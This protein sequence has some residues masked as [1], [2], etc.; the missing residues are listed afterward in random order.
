MFI[1]SDGV[2]DDKGEDQRCKQILYTSKITD[3]FTINTFGYGN[4]HDLKVLNHISNLKGGQFFYIDNIQTLSEC[5][6][7]AMSGML[8]IKAQNAM[9]NIK[10]INQN[11]KI[12]KIFGDD[13]FE[14]KIEFALEIE[15]PSSKQFDIQQAD[16]LSIELQGL[17]IEINTEFLKQSKLILQFSNQQVLAEQNELVEINY[18]RAKAG[19]IIGQAKQ[20]ANQKNFDQAQQLLNKMID[21]IEESFF[22]NNNQLLLVVK[23]LKKIKS[24]CQPQQY[25]KGGEAFTLHKQ[26]KHIK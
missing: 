2:D 12:F 18:L 6:I 16:V 19:D 25:Q 17:L 9:L 7:L 11:F 4:D 3:T 5:F 21:E 23:V 14:D 1:L 26:K 22:K 13:Y 8:S 20:Q 24:I 15:I 10:Q